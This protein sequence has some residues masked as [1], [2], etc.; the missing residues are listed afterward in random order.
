[1]SQ[2]PN[3]AHDA[4]F[5]KLLCSGTL[6]GHSHII[7]SLP[8]V[9]VFIMEGTFSLYY[10]LLYFIHRLHLADDNEMN[11]AHVLQL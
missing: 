4:D 2:W 10:E 1:M 11:A 6:K 7:I 3:T 8:L 9:L 5:L